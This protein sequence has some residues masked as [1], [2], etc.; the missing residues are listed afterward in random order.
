MELGGPQQ[1]DV[2]RGQ[3]GHVGRVDSGGEIGLL[4]QHPGQP[5]GEGSGAGLLQGGRVLAIRLERHLERPGPH[6][7]LHLRPGDA[8]RQGQQHGADR[9][10]DDQTP[11]LI[12]VPSPRT[13]GEHNAVM[14]KG[15]WGGEYL[16]LDLEATAIR[17]TGKIEDP[18]APIWKNEPRSLISTTKACAIQCAQG[19][20]N[21]TGQVKAAQ[22]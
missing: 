1:P 11:A 7:F 16:R 15:L 17:A 3:H 9:P 20:M 21:E 5:P 2:G 6:G 12:H 18:Q 10:P 8:E 22:F 19:A 4:G 13:R 14:Q